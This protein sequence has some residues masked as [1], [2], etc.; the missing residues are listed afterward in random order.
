V[1]NA[2]RPR[3]SFG[4]IVLNGEPFT[5]YCLRSLYPHAHQ[6]LVAEGACRAATGIGTADGHSSDG[7][8][9]TLRRFKAEQDPEGKITVITAE[10]EGHANG[11]WPGEKHEQSRAYAQRATGDILWQV[12]IDEFYHPHAIEAV[13][14]LFQRDP[15]VS[16]ASVRQVTFWGG[17]DYVTDSW[18]LRRGAADYHRI[19]RWG[20]GYAYTTHR[21]PTVADARGR[22]LRELNWLS[23]ETLVRAGVRLHHYSLLLPKQVFEKCAYY[24]RAAWIPA[25]A[26]TEWARRDYMGLRHP[27]RVHNVYTH[28]S[29]LERFGG[30]HPPEV[31][32]MRGDVEAGR[33]AVQLHDTQ[34]VELLLRSPRYRIGRLAIRSLDYPDRWVRRLRRWARSRTD[35][36]RNIQN[37]AAASAAETGAGGGLPTGA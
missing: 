36:V 4:V 12:D 23:A 31:E 13:R 29:W 17:F 27:F 30:E 15:T 35:H 26:Y 28:P 18:Y 14:G 10:D 25:D 8:L 7:T 32:R 33:L 16:G 1:T 21:P 9:E 11:F 6:I 19:F 34:S 20:P 3:I 37:S 24:D 5:S 22:N 2:S